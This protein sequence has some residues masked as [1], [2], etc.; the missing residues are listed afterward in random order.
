MLLGAYMFLSKVIVS[1]VGGFAVFR[2]LCSLRS[3]VDKSSL[4]Q[5]AR[6]KSYISFRAGE[7]APKITPD[8]RYV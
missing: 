1:F 2:I 7:R 4:L 5:T 8:R 6:L 3:E